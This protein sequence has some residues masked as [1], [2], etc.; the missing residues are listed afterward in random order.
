[1]KF[2]IDISKIC[3][4]NFKGRIFMKFDIRGNFENLSRKFQRTDFNEIWYLRTFR[5]NLSRKFQRTDFH[6][7]WYLRKFRKSVEEISKDGFS[8]NLIFEEN[9][10]ICRGNF[11]GRIF[12]KFDIWGNFE[13][14]HSTSNTYFLSTATVVT[15]TRVNAALYVLCLSCSSNH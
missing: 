14:T 10:K 15:R 7:I 6:E 3:R 2:D 4:G 1:M 11:K 12:M 8:W 13:H 5:K 9:S